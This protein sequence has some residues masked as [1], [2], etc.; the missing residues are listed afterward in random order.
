MD[1]TVTMDERW[2]PRRRK[3]E[4]RMCRHGNKAA[5]VASAARRR[6]PDK[7]QNERQLPSKRATSKACRRSW[8][9]RS[10]CGQRFSVL[11]TRRRLVR[12]HGEP[13]QTG[14]CDGFAAPRWSSNVLDLVRCGCDVLE[15][16]T[17][18]R[19][20]V[21]PTNPCEMGPR[22]AGFSITILSGGWNISMSLAVSAVFGRPHIRPCR[23]SSRYTLWSSPR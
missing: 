11:S 17:F 15:R 9:Q 8:R 16:S 19:I 14:T 1:G 2:A 22:A 5:I 10:A 6:D 21:G 13:H 7:V 4:P 18:P 12:G 23:P 3:P 20:V